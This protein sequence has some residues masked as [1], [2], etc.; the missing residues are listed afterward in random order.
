MTDIENIEEVEI[1]ADAETPATEP[2]QTD[3]APAA[4]EKASYYATMRAN[5]RQPF[6]EQKDVAYTYSP[7]GF[8]SGNFRDIDRQYPILQKMKEDKMLN[9]EYEATIWRAAATTPNDM[10]FEEALNYGIEQDNIEMVQDVEYESK[11][12]GLKRPKWPHKHG[13]SL[14]G[15]HAVAMMQYTLK[16]GSLLK[17]PCWASGVWVTLRAPTQYELADYNDLVAKE[18]IDIGKRTSG[19]VFGNSQVYLNKHLIDLAQRLLWKTSVVGKP[20]EPVNLKNILLIDDLETIA[21]ALGAIMFPNG[22]PFEEPCITDVEKCNKVIKQTINLNKIFW[23]NK[24]RLTKYQIMFMADE[25]AKHTMDDLHKYRA[26]ADWL[27]GTHVQY[28]GFKIYFKKPTIAEHIEAGYNWITEIE[29]SLKGV[30]DDPSEATLN[31][32]II[33]RAKLTALRG[34]GHYVNAIVFDNGARVDGKENI[35]EV[36][37][38]L[39]SMPDMLEKFTNDVNAYIHKTM[40][41]MCAINKF[42]CPDCGK[43]IVENEDHPYLAPVSALK[44][45]FNLLDQKLMLG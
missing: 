5:P 16:Q 29:E 11:T 37:N 17:F 30:I 9:K 14:S 6:V 20:D 10:V 28:D 22:Y 42:N 3:V 4:E 25:N 19:G 15:L 43:P 38:M 33:S 8:L 7:I 45:F 32:M 44:L 35:A 2:E 13:E 34:Y 40:I 23:V 21:W 36:I 26:E 1:S 18:L 27:E 31:D 24:K 12:I 39:S 41:S